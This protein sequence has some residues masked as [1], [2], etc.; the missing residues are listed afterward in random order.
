MT[1]KFCK[2]CNYHYYAYGHHR[3]NRPVQSKTDLVT[4]KPEIK[5]SY[6]FCESERSHDF[7]DYCGPEG[8]FWTPR[9]SFW[10]RL[11]DLITKSL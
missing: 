6:L 4:G 5:S 10:E 9:K 1:E 3:C 2:D 8:K 7:N 11:S